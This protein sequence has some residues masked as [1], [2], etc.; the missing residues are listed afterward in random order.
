MRLDIS[1]NARELTPSFSLNYTDSQGSLPSKNESSTDFERVSRFQTE[2]V[3]H[4][5][6]SRR[7][8]KIPQSHTLGLRAAG[9]LVL[10]VLDDDFMVDGELEA[11]AAS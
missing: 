4:E 6:H 5:S 8:S 2:N 7:G 11:G 3:Y 10:H 9:L 1:V